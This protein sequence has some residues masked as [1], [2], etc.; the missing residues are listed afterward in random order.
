MKE[1]LSDQPESQLNEITRLLK[2]IAACHTSFE[3]LDPNEKLILGRFARKNQIPVNSLS[4][5]GEQLPI[6]IETLRSYPIEQ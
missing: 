1:L 2:L 4:E 6:L 5:P 3:K